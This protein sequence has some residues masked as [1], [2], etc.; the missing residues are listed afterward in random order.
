MNA[1]PS[2][3]RN[4]QRPRLT[5]IP[6]SKGSSVSRNHEAKNQKQ[7][8]YQQ[9]VMEMTKKLMPSQSSDLVNENILVDNSKPPTAKLSIQISQKLHHQKLMKQPQSTSNIQTSQSKK[10]SFM[11]NTMI[12]HNVDPTAVIQSN[13][14]S[15]FKTVDTRQRGHVNQQQENF[16]TT[17]LTSTMNQFDKTNKSNISLI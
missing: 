12:K 3:T 17:S 9:N 16:N 11:N 8:S 1:Q 4:S 6:M 13:S 15:Q 10:N 2:S 7:L 5:M 14:M